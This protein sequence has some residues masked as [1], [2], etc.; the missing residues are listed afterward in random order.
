MSLFGRFTTMG[1]KEEDEP[2]LDDVPLDQLTPELLDQPPQ[3]TFVAAQ[4]AVKQDNL[5]KIQQYLDFNTKYVYC[6]DWDDSTL[7][8]KAAQYAR[9]DIVELLLKNNAD[10]NLTFNGKSPLQLAIESEYI[11]Q[12]RSAD[13]IKAFRKQRLATVRILLKYGA[14]INHVNE[15][16]EQAIH[17]AAKLGYAE[18]VEALLKQGSGLEAIVET[19][20]KAVNNAS[21]TPLIMAVRYAKDKTTVH[22]LLNSGA[23]PNRIDLVTGHSPLQLVVNCQDE[24][25][26]LPQLELLT[27]LLLKYKADINQQSEDQLKQ[28]ALHLAVIQRQFPLVE[29]LVACGADLSIKDAKQMMPIAIAARQGHVDLVK[30]LHEKGSDLYQSRA[31]FYA[32]NCQQSSAALEYLLDT[33]MDINMPDKSGYTPIFSAISAYSL[34][35]VKLLIDRGIDVKMYSPQGRTVLEHA[36]ACWGEVECLDKEENISEQQQLNSDNARD[37]IDLLGGF[38]HKRPKMY[39]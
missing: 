31:L 10:A 9:A 20:D 15:A 11:G 22:L 14:E 24:K 39:F 27:K 34:K 37:I 17:I 6:K 12:E 23:N 18:L 16:G 32:A 13:A 29:L 21:R 3:Y 30:F 26:Q 19:T 2:V 8:H 4:H 36:F 28:T 38:E 1:Q 25:V 7:L 5:D 35:N 33:G